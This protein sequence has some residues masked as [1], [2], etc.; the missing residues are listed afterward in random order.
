MVILHPAPCLRPR[1]GWRYHFQRRAVLAAVRW[2][3]R[4]W[5]ARGYGPIIASVA[6]LQ[7]V[8]DL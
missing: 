4:V 3:D 7:M 5:K 1:K 6:L 2:Q 8:A